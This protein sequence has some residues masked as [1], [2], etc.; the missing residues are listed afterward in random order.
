MSIPAAL[1]AKPSSASVGKLIRNTLAN[2]TN[3][4]ILS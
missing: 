4:E 1:A 2:L 3:P